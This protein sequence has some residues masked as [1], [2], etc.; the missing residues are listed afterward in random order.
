MTRIAIY[1][2]TLRDG[3]QGHGM[4]L[5]VEEKVRVAHAARRPRHPVHRGRLPGLEPQGGR[6]VRPAR[7]RGPAGRRVR[8]R[9]DPAARRHGRRRPGAARSSPSR[10][11][12]VCT[13][14]GKTWSLHLEKVVKVGRDENL[15]MIAESV[16][17]LIAQ[18]KRVIY[19][20]EHFF[21]GYRDDPAY[22]LACL[23]AAAWRGRRERHGVRHER[24]V[25]PARDRR[26]RARGGRRRRRPGRHPYPQRRRMRRGELAGGGRRGRR[27]WSRGR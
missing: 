24:R 3:M 21:D 1:E 19:D 10:S 6:A 20:A 11:R 27:A 25:A 23:R 7:A 17:F 18:G 12:P 8:V 2:T 13:V 4:S 9:D 22:A 26:R 16:A 14:V 15:A 5:S